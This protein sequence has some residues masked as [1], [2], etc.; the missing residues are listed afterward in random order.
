MRE[1]KCPRC[2]PSPTVHSFSDSSYHILRPPH[3]GKRLLQNSILRVMFQHLADLT[4]NSPTLLY[5]APPTPPLRPPSLSYS[6]TIS[7]FLRW[8]SSYILSWQPAQVVP[9][10]TGVRRLSA[11][12]SYPYSPTNS[13]ANP[14][15]DSPHT[16]S[17][18]FPVKKWP[19]RRLNKYWCRR[20][21]EW[22]LL[23]S[24]LWRRDVA[25]VYRVSSKEFFFVRT[26]TIPPVRPDQ[27]RTV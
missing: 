22:L 24:T 2:E 10:L 27:S 12:T 9:H 25:Y 17:Y 23:R 13:T 4:L 8:R 16:M 5:Q 3:E 26:S 1:P 11:Y 7:T 21:I 19:S 14:C 15:H 6:R 20:N 18:V